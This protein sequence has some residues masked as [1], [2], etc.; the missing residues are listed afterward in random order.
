MLS[1]CYNLDKVAGIIS[2]SEKFSGGEAHTPGI[3][4]DLAGGETRI[5]SAYGTLTPAE[6]RHDKA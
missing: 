4:A 1:I 3:W 2:T 6:L 5:R